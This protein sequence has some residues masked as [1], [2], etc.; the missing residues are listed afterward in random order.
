MK[1]LLLI[2]LVGCVNNDDVPPPRI[3]DVQPASAPPGSVVSISGSGFCQLPASMTG[4]PA[5]CDP[6]AV[7]F[8]TVPATIST[9]D[10]R[11][12]MVEVP[13]GATGAVT[14]V[15]IANARSSNGVA[16]TVD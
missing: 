6:G 10:D 5:A 4:D 13:A 1:A 15:V 8:D 3:G 14:L 9:W 7:D 11:S 2:A 12:I 16:F